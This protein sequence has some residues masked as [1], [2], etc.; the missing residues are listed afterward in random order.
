MVIQIGGDCITMCAMID[1]LTTGNILPRTGTG[2]NPEVRTSSIKDNLKV[3]W[4]S[5]DAHWSVILSL[6]GSTRQ[7][8]N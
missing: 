8:G 5:P 7:K 1:K 4:R 6:W 2:W 3:L